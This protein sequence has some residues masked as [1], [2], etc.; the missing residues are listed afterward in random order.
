MTDTERVR[1]GL[2]LSEKR[3]RHTEGVIAMAKKL[4]ARHFPDLPA[5]RA[6][7][8]ALLHDYTKEYSLEEHLGV[9]ADSGQTAAQ[10][11]LRTP[12]LLHARTGAEVARLIYG[13][14]SEICD[15]VRFH[16]T[17]APA[18]TPLQTVICLADFIEEGRTHNACA[19]VREYYE[20]QYAILQ[21]NTAL[22]L[23]LLRSLESTISHLLETGREICVT[24][25]QARNY[26]LNL[27]N[28]EG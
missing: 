28:K 8:C 18:M 9:L 3:M 24:S 25:V 21:T 15:A 16:T 10:E 22:Y 26:Y 2:R 20:A 11:E 14:D 17:G 12:E 23:A 6:E 7:L 4:A 19:A 27:L 13:F 5:E 1:R